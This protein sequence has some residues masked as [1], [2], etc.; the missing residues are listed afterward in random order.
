MISPEIQNQLRSQYN[1]DGSDLRKIQLRMLDILLEFDRICQKN[2]ITYWLDSGTLIGAARHGGFIPWDDDLDVCILHSDYR[3]LCRAVKKDLKMPYLFYDSDSKDNYARRWPRIVNESVR[4]TRLIPDANNKG[5][6]ISRTDNLWID[7]FQMIEGSVKVSRALSAF[8]GRC[9]R[10]RFN[11][12]DDG[13]ARHITG[14]ILYPLSLG[15][16]VLARI[17]GKV[18]HRNNL[19]HDFGS[20]FYSVRKR[21]DIFPLGKIEF[22]GHLLP[23]PRN[24]HNYLS[25]IYGDY[26]KLPDAEH[27]VTHNFTEI[28]IQ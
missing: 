24:T 10:R 20:G 5:S 19:I 25:R 9:Y 22:E 18:F 4:I 13:K 27:R 12:I 6:M 14:V 16:C 26:T 11:L 17:A 21:Q 23:A 2:G 1:P 8:Y 7:V 15:M 3:K 28:E